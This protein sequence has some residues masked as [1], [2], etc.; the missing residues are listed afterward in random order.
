MIY[1]K[2]YF[3]V[4]QYDCYQQMMPWMYNFLYKNDSDRKF[5]QEIPQLA[6]SLT[7]AKQVGN[8]QWTNEAV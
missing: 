7:A 5:R 4:G 3:A 8:F 6:T 1:G 2:K